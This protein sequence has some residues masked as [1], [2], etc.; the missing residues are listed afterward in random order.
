M[1]ILKQSCSQKEKEN[2][3]GCVSFRLKTATTLQSQ[4]EMLL[5]PFRFQIPCEHKQSSLQLKS[6]VREPKDRFQHS[7]SKEFSGEYSGSVDCHTCSQQSNSVKLDWVMT[8]L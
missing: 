1:Q 3:P 6:C 7:R 8:S 2:K 5:L 4:E